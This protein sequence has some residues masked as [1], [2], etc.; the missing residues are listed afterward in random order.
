MGF[1]IMTQRSRNL[2]SLLLYTSGHGAVDTYVSLLQCATP[3]IAA[4]L[5]LH[6]GD[7]VILVGVSGLVNNLVQPF[8]GMLMARRNVGGWLD[9]MV[10]LSAL[11]C[12]MGWSA[13]FWM[14]ALL[15][16]LGD[17]GTG[18][19]HPEAIL[20]S[21]DVAGDK[22]YLG[23]PMFMAGG[24]GILAVATPL[25]IWLCEA[26][27][28]RALALLF[29]PG[30]CVAAGLMFAWRS[31]RRQHPSI[32]NRPRSARRG[33]HAPNEMSFWP[34]LL[35]GILCCMAHGMFLAVFASHYELV[36]GQAARIYAGWVLM[37]IGIGC[38]L[39]S[40]FWNWL[41]MRMR[42]YVVAMCTQLLAAPLYA[43][44]AQP[45][46]PELGILI[47]LPLSLVSPA[48]IHPVSIT[49]SRSAYGLTQSMRASLMVGG[50]YTISGLTVM[51]AGWLLR[52]G[53]PS[54][55]LMYFIAACSACAVLVC[56]YEILRGK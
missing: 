10:L 39:A 27:T 47:A 41:R 45:S 52:R 29:I 38:S 13:N 43:L 17:I 35:F 26:W 1:H 32:V 55:D 40:F 51:G 8:V 11:P 15:I 3:A 24:A 14:L 42:F 4:Y 7:L 12:F 18:V 54:Q 36:F 53:L 48:S 34:L 19:Y 44:L 56:L 33:V 46:G 2:L 6:L 37:V 22:P 9:L 31:R 30:A 50:T 21:D 5:G 23:I 20:A 25:S 28:P 49:L 16:I